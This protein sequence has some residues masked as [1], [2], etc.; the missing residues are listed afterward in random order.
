MKKKILVLLVSLLAL[1]CFAKTKGTIPT[2]MGNSIIVATDQVYGS[3]K[4]VN[5]F[6]G[7]PSNDISNIT[8]TSSE[9]A[10]KIVGEILEDD[11]VALKFEVTFKFSKVRDGGVCYPTKLYYEI[12]VTFQN[13]TIYCNGG[14]YNNPESF[15]QIMGMLERFQQFA[16]E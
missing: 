8:I 10:L 5:D 2:W 15:G 9:D 12:P 3:M 1:S 16:Y 13:G 6:F 11:I 14:P 7:K 4:T